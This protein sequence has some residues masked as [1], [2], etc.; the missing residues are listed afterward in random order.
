MRRKNKLWQIVNE[1]KTEKK[2]RKRRKA[3]VNKCIKSDSEGKCK[4]IDMKL[5]LRKSE[6][7][8]EGNAKG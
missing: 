4:I 1:T 8:I 6:N 2:E 7:E 5:M 3:L